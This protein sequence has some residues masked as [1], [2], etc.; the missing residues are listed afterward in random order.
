M[1]IIVDKLPAT[2]KECLFAKQTVERG[3]ICTLQHCSCDIELGLR[4]CPCL[5][6]ENFCEDCFWYSSEQEYCS[7]DRPGILLFWHDVWSGRK[8]AEEGE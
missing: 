5:R 3:Y 6:V 7:K 8:K 4:E 2:P 1:K